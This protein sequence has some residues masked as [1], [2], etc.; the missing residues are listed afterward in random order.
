MLRP[1]GRHK[2]GCQLYSIEPGVYIIWRSLLE[3]SMDATCLLMATGQ[4]LAS[5]DDGLGLDSLELLFSGAN[6]GSRSSVGGPD[7]LLLC[8][9]GR[10]Q[11]RPRVSVHY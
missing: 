6:P 2:T 5:F 10:G 1:F 3:R 8:D 9:S 7:I 4:G 11:K